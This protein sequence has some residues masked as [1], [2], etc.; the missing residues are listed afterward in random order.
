MHGYIAGLIGCGDTKVTTVLCCSRN[1]A[2]AQEAAT[3]SRVG[4]LGIHIMADEASAKDWI[5]FGK[6]CATIKD[7]IIVHHIT[8]KDR[9]SIHNCVKDCFFYQCLLEYTIYITRFFLWYERHM[10]YT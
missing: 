9:R 10:G 4:L 5:I 1:S 2:S 8:K 6:S 3:V 7:K